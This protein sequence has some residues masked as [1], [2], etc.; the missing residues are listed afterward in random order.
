MLR[1]KK[2][3][4]G[5]AVLVVGLSAVLGA[6]VLREPIAIA[7]TPFQN[8]IVANTANQ[9]VPVAVASNANVVRT[10][11]PNA[12]SL[13]VRFPTVTANDLGTCNVAVFDLP[14][15]VPVILNSAVIEFGHGAVPADT[16]RASINI[17]M[18]SAAGTGSAAIRDVHVAV[19]ITQAATGFGGA[20][21]IVDLGG[22]VAKGA[23]SADAAIGQVFSV[24][25]CVNMGSA[26]GPT[27]AEAMLNI[28]LPPN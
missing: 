19:P 23:P 27:N 5:L 10:A 4:I 20:S 25:A 1:H 21:G 14:P 16:P 12:Q 28:T 7:A 6:T 24:E 11:V 18:R 8:V 22:V 15:D 17:R 3:G 2:F 13:T 26:A 9:P